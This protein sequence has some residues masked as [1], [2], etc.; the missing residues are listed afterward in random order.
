MLRNRIL[1]AVQ[2]RQSFMGLCVFFPEMPHLL[3][4]RA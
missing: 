4:V 3:L 2:S 1:E